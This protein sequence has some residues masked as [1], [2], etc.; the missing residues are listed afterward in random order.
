MLALPRVSLVILI[1]RSR[2]QVAPLCGGLFSWST[3]PENRFRQPQRRARARRGR[4]MQPLRPPLAVYLHQD[5]CGSSSLRAVMAAAQSLSDDRWLCDMHVDALRMHV[6]NLTIAN[7][8]QICAQAEVVLG[9]MGYGV[10][11]MFGRAC[12]YFTILREPVTRMISAYNYFCL[13]CAERGK[14]CD[15]QRNTSAHFNARCPQMRFLEFASIYANLYTWRFSSRYTFD[16]RDRDVV[17]ADPKQYY[18]HSIDGFPENDPLTE[19]DFVAA[20]N[21]LNAPDMLVLKTEELNTGGWQKLE[22]WLSG[23]KAAAALRRLDQQHRLD[24]HNGISSKNMRSGYQYSPRA[25]EKERVCV[26][27]HFDCRLYQ[28]LRSHNGSMDA[29]P[30]I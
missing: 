9:P 12:R 15:D 24:V 3:C 22:W 5:K 17:A 19:S 29:A 13:S 26:I 2:S 7:V 16:P 25:G 23:T 1:S 6:N 20:S 27:N 4:E 11:S 14:F 18:L 8:S 30:L 10:C 21:A 28:S